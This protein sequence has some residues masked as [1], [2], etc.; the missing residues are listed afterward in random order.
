[1]LYCGKKKAAPDLMPAENI[2]ITPMDD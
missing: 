2:W 1:M